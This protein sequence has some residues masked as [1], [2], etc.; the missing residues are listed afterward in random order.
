[1]LPGKVRRC[2]LPDY[3]EE[4]L[5][6]TG[7][8]ADHVSITMTRSGDK[9]CLSGSSAS[10]RLPLNC[11]FQ[12]RLLALDQSTKFSALRRISFL[13]THLLKSADVLLNDV[14]V[15]GSQTPFQTASTTILV[16]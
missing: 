1:M 16:L 5:D 2:E 4:A 6:Q 12:P 8:C 3:F 9:S 7:K 11:L 13:F 10:C 15:H 14:W